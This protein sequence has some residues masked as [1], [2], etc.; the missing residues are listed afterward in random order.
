[1]QAVRS[2]LAVDVPI[3]LLDNSADRAL[4]RSPLRW[5]TPWTPITPLTFAQ[6][7]NVARQYA[8]ETGAP[9]YAFLHNDAEVVG[10]LAA[11]LAGPMAMH[12]QTASWGALF[13]NYDAFAVFNP[14]AM[15]AVGPWDENIPWYYCDNDMYRRL[16]LAG[17]PIHRVDLAV[18]HHVSQTLQAD[19]QIQRH[20]DRLNN[21]ISQYYIAKWGGSPGRERFQVPWE[22]A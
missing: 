12:M 15:R 2:V 14:V 21:V 13:T 9:W 7:M 3:R 17:Y 22:G 4:S 1:M 8:L 5:L 6:S 11:A 18:R 19:T 16:T 10:D 20:T